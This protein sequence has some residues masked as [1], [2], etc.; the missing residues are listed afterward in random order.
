MFDTNKVIHN[1]AGDIFSN[2]KE[3]AIPGKKCFNCGKT[4][5]KG[6][7]WYYWYHGDQDDRVC[8]DCAK[9]L[10]H[11]DTAY[12]GLNVYKTGE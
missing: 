11:T 7:N 4:F 8:V 1:I 2:N 9:K 6:D 12:A 3:K 5:I 10:K